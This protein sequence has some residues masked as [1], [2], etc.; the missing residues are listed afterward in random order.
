MVQIIVVE[1][2][3]DQ[4]YPKVLL[5]G[6]APSTTGLALPIIPMKRE[7]MAGPILVPLKPLLSRGESTMVSLS[8]VVVQWPCYIV[9]KLRQHVVALVR[10]SRMPLPLLALRRPCHV[11]EQR[12]RESR[13]L[14]A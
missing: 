13:T 2:T 5:T 7:V 10:I 12:E 9:P 8:I 11:G 3:K 1:A 14:V 4:E 6:A